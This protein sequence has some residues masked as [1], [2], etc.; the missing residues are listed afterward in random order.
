LKPGGRIIL[1]LYHWGSWKYHVVL[2]LKRLIDPSYRGKSQSEA[3][4]MNDGQDC[5]LAMVYTRA[6]ARDLL[7]SFVDHRFALNQ[8]SWRQLLLVRGL[9]RILEP[10]LPSAN[11][12]IFA[13]AMG[14]NMYVTAVKPE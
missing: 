4:N 7:A 11:R 13:R 14:W 9:D 10:L 5:P 2:R 12:S 6:Q 8:L 1:M 3:L